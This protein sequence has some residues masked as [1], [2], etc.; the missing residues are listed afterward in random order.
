VESLSGPVVE[1]VGD[2]VQVAGAVG[3]QVA[4]L[5][6]V[7]AQQAVGVLVAAALPGGLLELTDTLDTEVS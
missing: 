7:L 6:E 3:G 2:V 5:G 1:L 4:A